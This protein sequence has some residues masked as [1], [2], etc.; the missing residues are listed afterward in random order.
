MKTITLILAGVSILFSACSSTTTGGN[1]VPEPKVADL[2]NIPVAKPDPM[3]RKNMFISPYRPYNI[4][5]CKGYRRGDV[6]GDP[7]TAKRDSSGKIIESTSKYF[8]IP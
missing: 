4:I 3:G 5:D 2:G 1:G 6:V 8:L 7:S